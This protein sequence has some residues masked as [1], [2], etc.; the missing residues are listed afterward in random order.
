MG[1]SLDL[2]V[3]AVH[4]PG[5]KNILADA[6]SRPEAP[7]PTEWQLCPEVF[8]GLCL[9]FGTPLIDLFATCLNHQLPTYV[10][11]VPDPQAWALDALSLEWGGWTLMLFHQQPSS[12]R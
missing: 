12:P 5:A 8:Q 10:S 2:D 4:I 3:R 7:P 11:P 6:L 1:P 9:Q